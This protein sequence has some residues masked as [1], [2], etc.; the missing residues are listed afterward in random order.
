M[1]LVSLFFHLLFALSSTGAL[2][3]LLQYSNYVSQFP[4]ASSLS[5]THLTI[6][7]RFTMYSYMMAK[8]SRRK[9]VRKI[10]L[11]ICAMGKKTSSKPMKEIIKRLPEELIDVN[12]F[13]EDMILNEP[14]ENWPEV[15]C[16][17]AFYSNGYPLEKAIAYAEKVKPFLLNDLE[18]QVILK[19]RRK[20]YEILK[21]IDVP[22]ARHVFLERDKPST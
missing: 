8:L 6:A 21:S 9:Q 22:V 19:D 10:R 14:I 11:G 15:E 2:H 18:M 13:P 5:P 12:I 16:L 17:I 20:V 4:I 3:F 1:F 7:T